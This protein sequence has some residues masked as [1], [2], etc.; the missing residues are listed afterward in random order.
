MEG[1]GIIKQACFYH[2]PQNG[3]LE[4]QWTDG[5]TEMTVPNDPLGHKASTCRF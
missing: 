5:R 2:P 4:E 1:Y 3:V